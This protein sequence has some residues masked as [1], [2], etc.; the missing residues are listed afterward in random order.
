[1]A[2]SERT[3]VVRDL[4]IAASNVTVA[5]TTASAVGG[6][7]VWPLGAVMFGFSS[8]LFAAADRS[9]VGDWTLGAALSA[10]VVG[11]AL[12]LSWAVP[13]PALRIIP[14][15]LL[16]LGVGTA[17]NRLLYGVVYPLPEPRLR[18]ENLA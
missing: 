3:V 8:L 9:D 17:A 15:L 12:A 10:A 6:G 5:I 4:V 7:Q 16:G 2:R 13:G 18:R 14:P 11:A 1:M